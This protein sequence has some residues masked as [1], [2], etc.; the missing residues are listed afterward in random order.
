MQITKNDIWEMGIDFN[1]RF[2]RYRR[3]WK[4]N[5][6]IGAMLRVLIKK[7]PNTQ[8]KI[9]HNETNGD[10][11]VKYQK[12]GQMESE[13]WRGK[14]LSLTLLKM[15]QDCVGDTGEENANTKEAP[16]RSVH[17]PG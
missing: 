10:Y 16:N 1:E 3:E 14:V 11:V 15:Y 8:I 2:L 7:M 4:E 13:L 17:N 6:D 9:R 5:S 12:E